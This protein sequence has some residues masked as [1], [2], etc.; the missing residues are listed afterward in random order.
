VSAI[1][2]YAHRYKRPPRKRAKAAAIPAPAIVQADS[3]A[4]DPEQPARARKPAIV[5]AR[6]PRAGKDAPDLTPEE[7]QRRADAAAALF[8]KITTAARRR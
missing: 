7:L 4:P 8:R 1:V 6:K 3:P 2:T 5:T